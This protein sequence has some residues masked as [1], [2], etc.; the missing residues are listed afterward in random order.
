MFSRREIFA[1]DLPLIRT[2]LRGGGKSR[3][4]IERCTHHHRSRNDRLECYALFVIYPF[5]NIAI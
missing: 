4:R 3:I 5:V 1:S 2:F